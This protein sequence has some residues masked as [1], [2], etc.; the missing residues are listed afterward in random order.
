MQLSTLITVMLCNE[1]KNSNM[2]GSTG[3]AAARNVNWECLSRMSQD[4]VH[5]ELQWHMAAS[6]TKSPL[7]LPLQLNEDELWTSRSSPTSRYV[8]FTS[9]YLR[10]TDA[11]AIQWW[12]GILWPATTVHAHVNRFFLLLSSAASTACAP[13][14]TLCSYGMSSLSP[15]HST[16]TSTA[17]PLAK[18]PS[19]YLKSCK[20]SSIEGIT[21]SEREAVLPSC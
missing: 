17:S 4:T 3:I 13:H 15:Q 21:Y 11:T 7:R 8:F 10:T 12:W 14:N 16:W 1:I 6:L 19:S 2:A 5:Q 20:P 18:P 9:G